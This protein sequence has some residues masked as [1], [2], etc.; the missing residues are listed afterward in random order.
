M[1][2]FNNDITIKIS[3]EL[4]NDSFNLSSIK[5]TTIR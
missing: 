4:L 5:T 2:N 1:N 3:N